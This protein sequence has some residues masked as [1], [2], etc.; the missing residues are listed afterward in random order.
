MKLNDIK[1]II[2]PSFP[3]IIPCTVWKN[4]EP[5]NDKCGSVQSAVKQFGEAEV[6]HIEPFINFDKDGELW[7][8]IEIK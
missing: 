8:A 4:G 5:V 6:V 2:T 3:R 1:G 7:L